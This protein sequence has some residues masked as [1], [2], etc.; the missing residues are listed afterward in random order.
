MLTW[1]S[2]NRPGFPGG[3][4]I[5]L[6]GK[7]GSQDIRWCVGLCILAICTGCAQIVTT[8]AK[9]SAVP[10]GIRVYPPRVLLFVDEGK[11]S[12]KVI[13]VPDL[14]HGYDVKSRTVLAK[15]DFEINLSDGG[16]ISK[17]QSNGDTSGFLTFLSGLAQTGAKAAGLPVS[18]EGIDGT[19]GLT[20]GVYEIQT[21]GTFQCIAGKCAPGQSVQRK[22]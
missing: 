22:D 18:A 13:Y 15:R 16:M 7:K 10:S 14:K 1:D 6:F 12:S 11:G 19:F 3:I 5:D 20:L 17:V 8:E 2:L 9:D 4:P 21:D